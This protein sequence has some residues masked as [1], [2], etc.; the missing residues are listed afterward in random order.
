MDGTKTWH[1][2]IAIGRYREL[3]ALLG[4]AIDIDDKLIASEEIAEDDISF[5]LSSAA[6]DELNNFDIN[7]SSTAA[8]SLTTGQWYVMRNVGRNG[9][10]YEKT[11]DHK[12]YTQATKP[13]GNASNN[14]QSLVRLVEDGNGKYYLQTGFGN[15]F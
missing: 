4:I 11:A 1:I 2:D 15:Y 8:T 7:V 9:Y 13:S 5:P 3:L 6:L 12:L 10:L 14:A